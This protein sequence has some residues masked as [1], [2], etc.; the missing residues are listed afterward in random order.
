LLTLGAESADPAPHLL[1]H[2]IFQAEGNAAESARHRARYLE[3]TSAQ[4][5]GGMSGNLAS[6]KLRRFVP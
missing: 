2:Q 4:N 1:L 5:A 6:R 3:L